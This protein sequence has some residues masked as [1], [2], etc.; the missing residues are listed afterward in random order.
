MGDSMTSR[1]IFLKIMNFEPC[2]RT[3]KWDFGYWGG[4]I[5]RWYS[6]GMKKIK[7]LPKKVSYGEPVL[8]GGSPFPHYG[9]FEDLVRAKDVDINF[10]LDQGFKT[11]PFNYWIYPT[12]EEKTVFEDELYIDK[13]G[14]DGIRTRQLKDGSS[15]P[16]W[17]EFPVKDRNSW[18]KIKEERFNF[19]SIDK[20][21]AK[22]IGSFTK[23][24]KERTFPLGILNNPTG[25]FGSL[26]SLIGDEKLF[27]LYYDDPGLIKDM[28]EH[29]C[30]LWLHMVEELTSRMEFDL[31]FFWEDMSGKNGSLISPSTFKEFMSPI[32]K[33]S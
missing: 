11:V 16:M 30:N 10:N 23:E 18:E 1:E 19:D 20:R 15:M 31:A 24:A 2:T 7:G 5:N 12:F 28:A 22:D 21:F 25:Y 4:A 14:R 13:Y 9:A 6:E 29:F 17:L 3:L 27:M 8:G 33:K 32:T 26:R